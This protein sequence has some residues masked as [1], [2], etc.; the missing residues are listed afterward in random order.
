MIQGDLSGNVIVITNSRKY[1]RK[2]SK[3]AKKNCQKD[4]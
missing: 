2:Y 4:I 3:V 1:Q